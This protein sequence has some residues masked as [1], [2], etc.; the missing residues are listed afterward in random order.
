MMQIISKVAYFK[1]RPST[2]FGRGDVEACLGEIMEMAT[3]SGQPSV[4]WVGISLEVSQQ[5]Q[6]CARFRENRKGT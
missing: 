2:S 4:L 5:W 1:K 3:M 6:G